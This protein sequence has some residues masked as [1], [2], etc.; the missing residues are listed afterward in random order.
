MAIRSGFFNSVNGDRKYNARDISRLFDGMITD[1]VFL[2]WGNHFAMEPASSGL[3]VIV[4][5]GRCWFNHAWVENDSNYTA[6]FSMA[7]P[8]LSRTDA[9]VVEIDERDEYRRGTIKIVKGTAGGGNP[10]ITKTE[11][12]HQYVLAYVT[13]PAAATKLTASAITIKVGQGECPYAAGILDR[14]PIDEIWAQ[15]NASFNEW[16][17]SAKNT[18][19]TEWSGLKAQFNTEWSGLKTQFNT[20]WQERKDEFDTWFAELNTILDENVATNLYNMIEEVN[21]SLN[22]RIDE[23]VQ[24]VDDTAGELVS[25]TSGR[26]V[27]AYVSQVFTESGTF[28]LDADIIRNDD[29]IKV[30]AVGPGGNGWDG[31]GTGNVGGGGGGGYV[32]VVNIGISTLYTNLVDVPVTITD[33]VTSFGTLVSASKGGDAKPVSSNYDSSSK[34]YTI[35][36][37]TGGT[38]GSGGGGG[39]TGSLHDVP[40]LSESYLKWTLKLANGGVGAFGGG[41]GG[42]GGCVSLRYSTSV[43][44]EITGG[45]GGGASTGALPGQ[46][47]AKNPNINE[48]NMLK[49]WNPGVSGG[50]G[51]A[52]PTN[53]PTKIPTES[54]IGGNGS[55]DYVWA[56]DPT[57]SYLLWG[58][59]GGG[60]GGGYGGRGGDG[61]HI[62]GVSADG[63]NYGISAK[64]GN[65]YG[66]GGGGNG[67]YG[68]GGGGGYG[69]TH[70][71]ETDTSSLGTGKGAKGIVIIQY[72]KRLLV[73]DS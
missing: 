4:K 69:S 37:S 6:T 19:S 68:G 39:G 57:K 62:S 12:V 55:S 34:V 61:G 27:T 26:Y 73:L 25:S 22:T 41:G 24:Y 67:I 11:Q 63:D 21:T 72:Y 28:T 29:V 3:S 45:Y 14:V 9:I 59:N 35:T 7:D 65:G 38:G 40:V 36:Y 47:S 33:T 2:H 17:T 60:G 71:A 10:S 30:I 20:E 58:G 32:R 43:T 15:W 53:A 66:A 48:S 5:S 31:G 23:V 46:G 51:N 54:A 8:A 52:A 18:F 50:T 13:I 70:F 44:V 1:G 64:G 49:L 16:F 42:G 56:K